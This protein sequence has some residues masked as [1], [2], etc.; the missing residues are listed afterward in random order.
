MAGGR[1]KRQRLL[2]VHEDDLPAALCALGLSESLSAGTLKCGFCQTILT[3]ESLAGWGMEDHQVIAFCG[4][5]S[6]VAAA[7]AAGPADRRVAD[8]GAM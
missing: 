8:G 5:P 1:R 4:N 3:E 2:A 7:H 6:C